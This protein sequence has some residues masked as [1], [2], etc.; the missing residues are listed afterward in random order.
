M[1]FSTKMYMGVRNVGDRDD[2]GTV[3]HESVQDLFERLIWWLG[4]TTPRKRIEIVIASDKQQVVNR[5]MS[6]KAREELSNESMF[7]EVTQMMKKQ[8]QGLLDQGATIDPL[9]D[10][11]D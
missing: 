1:R 10:Y 2:E 3:W 7:D 9:D 6:T 4:K 8:E 11:A 5:L